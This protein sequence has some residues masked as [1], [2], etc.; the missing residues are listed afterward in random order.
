MKTFTQ[1]DVSEFGN[2][3]YRKIF[4]SR[5]DLVH[6]PLEWQKLGLQETVSGYGAKLTT[7]EKISFEGKLYRIYATQFSNA[8]SVWFKYK[9]NKIFIS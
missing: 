5:E 4:A 9:G 8:G 6:C 2:G 7:Q 1:K 3:N